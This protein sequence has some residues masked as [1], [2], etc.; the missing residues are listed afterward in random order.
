MNFNLIQSSTGNI[1]IHGTEREK[2]RTTRN[3]TGRYD[4]K[5]GGPLGI[6]IYEQLNGVGAFLGANKVKGAL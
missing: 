5:K 6:G 3:E 2:G 4:V 1:R